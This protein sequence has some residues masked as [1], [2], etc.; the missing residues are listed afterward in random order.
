MPIKT[1]KNKHFAPKYNML[2]RNYDNAEIESRKN[3]PVP[4]DAR[5]APPPRTNPG[6][7]VGRSQLPQL[8]QST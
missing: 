3:H 5:L 6:R 7:I 8:F 4:H 1:V 2:D